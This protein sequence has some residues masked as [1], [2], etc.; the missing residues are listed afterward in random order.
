MGHGIAAGQHASISSTAQQDWAACAAHAA[1]AG[2]GDCS[3]QQVP[4]QLVQPSS[5]HTQAAHL[6]M[7]SSGSSTCSC[8]AAGTYGSSEC[9]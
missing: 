7:T 2:A 8:R 9:Q 3:A 6:M 4:R 1:T 5:H